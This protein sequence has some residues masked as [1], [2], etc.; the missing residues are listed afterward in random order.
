MKKG[1]LLLALL[2]MT[3]LR[4]GS[5][6]DGLQVYSLKGMSKQEI[7]DEQLLKPQGVGRLYEVMQHIDTLFRKHNI[8]YWLDGGS[9]LGAV[10]HGGLMPWDNDIDL[11]IF[12]SDAPKVEKLEKEFK[13]IG[14]EMRGFR[15][16]KEHIQRFTLWGEDKL[17]LDIFF[18]R[19]VDID[20]KVELSHS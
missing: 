10:R 2:S 5:V 17:H 16:G 4:C 8:H 19:V 12:V 6:L 18:T 1:F 7:I 13:K 3:T 20:G 9:L 15:Q 14:L 11:K